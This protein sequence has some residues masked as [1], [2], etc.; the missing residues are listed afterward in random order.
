VFGSAPIKTYY[1]GANSVAEAVKKAEIFNKHEKECED[2]QQDVL[3]ADGSLRKEE[4]EQE[5]IITHVKMISET[6]II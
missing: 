5:F 6:I 1:V 4:E 3:D 2:L